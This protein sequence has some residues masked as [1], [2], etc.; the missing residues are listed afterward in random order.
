MRNLFISICVA[1]A[2]VF[3]LHAQDIIIT[4]DAQKIEAVITEVTSKDVSYK[5]MSNPDG[6]TFVLEKSLISSIIYKNGEVEIISD[7]SHSVPQQEEIVSAEQTDSEDD[8]VDL[9]LPSGTLWKRHNEE[10]V[11]THNEA[12]SRFGNALPSKEQFK[13]LDKYCAFKLDGSGINWIG[14]NGNSIHFESAEHLTCSGSLLWSGIAKIKINIWTST[15]KNA[16]KAWF[17]TFYSPGSGFPF[18]STNSCYGFSVH[19]VR[20]K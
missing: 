5:K 13:E 7:A 6:P 9:G 20:S 16:S 19:L 12:V 17:F 8:Y 1:F 10:G 18:L 2:A 14:K 3:S 4:Q 11:F 15:S